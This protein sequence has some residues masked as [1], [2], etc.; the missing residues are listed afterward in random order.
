[1]LSI[2]SPGFIVAIFMHI[3]SEM[4]Y[5]CYRRFEIYYSRIEVYARGQLISEVV[6]PALA[7]RLPAFL[8]SCAG[9]RFAS[10]DCTTAQIGCPRVYSCCHWKKPAESRRDTYEPTRMSMWLSWL[11][12]VATTIVKTNFFL[13]V[14][15]GSG[16]KNPDHR[17]LLLRL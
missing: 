15:I 4:H 7:K 10:A 17:G 14:W 16:F 1:M 3:I 11:L 5:I 9:K 2:C 13:L 12:S 6:Q 8:I